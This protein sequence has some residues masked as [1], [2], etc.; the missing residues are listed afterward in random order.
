MDTEIEICRYYADFR[1]TPDGQALLVTPEGTRS[2]AFSCA[3]AA[4]QRWTTMTDA[5][6]AVS[7]RF[8]CDVLS[9]GSR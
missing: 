5:Q 9:D 2:K 1:N 4:G 7:F 3:V 6:K 8:V